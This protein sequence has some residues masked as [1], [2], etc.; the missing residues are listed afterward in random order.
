M[1]II[2]Y[3][4]LITKQVSL[5]QHLGFV[6]LKANLHVSDF[7]RAGRVNRQTQAGKNMVNV[8]VSDFSSSVFGSV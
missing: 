1:K 2:P 6:S 5:S 3:E 7:A 8:H 4:L